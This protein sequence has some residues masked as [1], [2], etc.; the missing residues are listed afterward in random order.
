[1]TDRKRV[2]YTV[3]VRTAP[4]TG[5]GSLPAG[6]TATGLLKLIALLLMLTDHI[7]AVIFPG[8]P[9]LRI[10]GRAAFPVYCWCMVVGFCY[11]R[12][13]WKYLLRI[14]ITGLVSQPLYAVAMN[15][16]LNKANIFLTLLLGLIAL[17]GLRSRK[18]FSQIWAPAAAIAL[19]VLLKA[20]YGWKGVLLII[21]LYAARTS[22]P[23]IA[24]V[25][26][27]LFLYWGTSYSVTR[28]LFGIPIDL[29]V[30]PEVL[31]QPLTAFM[32][33]ET[34]ALLSLPLILIR[35]PKDVR[36]PRWVGYALY[37]AHLLLIIL[38]KKLILG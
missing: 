14:L 9:E 21:L 17:W 3:P 7:G 15:H 31:S 27:A 30:L 5:N 24:G 28:S 8:I 34:Y 6:N 29:N 36:Y 26:V 2:F 16:D 38:L 20:D 1:M 35:F 23:A 25:M 12:C 32:R 33:L 11:T 19:A 22:R 13:E 18:W 4:E 37:P 10:I